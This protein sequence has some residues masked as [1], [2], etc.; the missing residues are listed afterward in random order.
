MNRDRTPPHAVPASAA[1][2][3]AAVAAPAVPTALPDLVAI[4]VVAAAAWRELAR[5][6]RLLSLGALLALP[7][8]LLFAIRAFYPGEAPADLLLSLLAQFVYIPFLLPIT[9]MALGAPAISEPIAEGTLVYYWTRPL[10]RRALYL[11]RILAAALVGCAMILL[12]QTAVF[13]TLVAGG[14]GDPSLA[15][16]RMH[17]ELTVV[18][19]LGALAYTAVF[20]CFGAGFKKP[21][22]PALLLAFGWESMVVGIPQRIQ[23]WSLRFHLRNLVTWPETRPTDLR[24]FLSDLLNQ[25]LVRPEVPAWHS[26]LVLVAV[27]LV[28]TLA[29]IVLLRR[30]Q[31]DRQG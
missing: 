29:G 21:L 7:V 26:V 2:P 24:G 11:G 22:V 19:L 30:R 28:T 8:L 31:L 23:E 27:I 13:M 18:A 10:N 16:L 5:R 20:G 25:V 17:V 3:D 12:S 1:A 6:R 9:A 15:L 4:T 14:F